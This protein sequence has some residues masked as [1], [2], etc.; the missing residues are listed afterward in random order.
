MGDG[1]PATSAMF[2]DPLNV[3]VDTSGNLYIIDEYNHRIRKVSSSGIITTVA[4][5]G[6][7]GFSGDGGPGDLR[8]H[9]R[10]WSCRRWFRK[11][12]PH[13]AGHQSRSE[14]VG[15]RHHLDRCGQRKG[16]VLWRWRPGDGGIVVHPVG[17]AV[18]SS[19][20]LYIADSSN[21][22]VRKVSASGIITT[23]AG[24]GASG[25][26][27]EAGPPPRHES[28]PPGYRRGYRREYLFLGHSQQSNPEGIVRRHHQRQSRATEPLI[29]KP[30]RAL[31]AG[32]EGRQHRHR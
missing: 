18:D 31:F 6:T 26:S 1:G 16:R 17:V 7:S 32:T 22:R 14:G 8:I 12:L 29:H 10:R 13:R 20:N 30:A 2:A 21:N 4:G 27:G 23:I 28:G 25:F 15:Q 11:S 24:T 3:A 19:G 5:N 9:Y